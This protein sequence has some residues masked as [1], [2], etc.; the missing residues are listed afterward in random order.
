MMSTV[1]LKYGGTSIEG[2]ERLM[3]V[4]RRVCKVR[5]S[6]LDVVVVVS[7]PGETTDDLIKMAY[8]INPSPPKR[9]MDMLLSTGERI[10]VALLSIAIAS[11]GFPAISFTGSQAGIM[12]DTVHTKAKIVDIKTERIEKELRAGKIVIVAG[13]QGV[14]T[15]YDIT[16]L[17]RGGSDTT[18]VALAAALNADYCEIL[19]DVDGIYSA[20]PKLV[21]GARKLQALSYEEMLEMSASGARVLALRSV[22][23]ARKHRVKIHVKSSFNEDQGTWIKEGDGTMEKAMVSGVTYN[24][25]EAKVTIEN[26]PDRPG[27]AA[28][29][30][31]TLAEAQINVDVIIQN[32]S[33][34]GL[35]DISFTVSEEDLALT[36][37]I[38]GRTV[39]EQG[40]TG[41]SF[42]DKIAK[43]SI[44]GAGMRSNPGVAAKMFS[45]LAD[46]G[47][48][49]D[50]INTSTIRISC[51]ISEDKVEQA[52]RALHGAFNLEEEAARE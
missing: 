26:V 50:M 5:N 44:I 6:G 24:S 12:T 38:V 22:E 41:F 18:A 14:S 36:R 47:I 19:T 32:T 15:A 34:Q 10:S 37:E 48:N 21:P 8:E 52:I 17:G 4:A 45:T 11:C 9:E 7:A 3:N 31:N 30:F 28:K 46:N 1:V 33:H 27:V 13:F 42:D 51:V 35:A 39:K 49:I 25:N 40:A 29:V 20:D 43:I 16:T 23:F 2:S